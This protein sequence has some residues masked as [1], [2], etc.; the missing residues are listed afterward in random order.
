MWYNLDE[1]NQPVE[2]TI[3]E[4]IAW[5][6]KNPERKAVKQISVGDTYISTVFMGLDHGW[7]TRIPVLWETMI[8]GGKHD[9]YQKRYTSHEDAL[10]GHKI[11]IN[12]VK[13]EKYGIFYNIWNWISNGCAM[14]SKC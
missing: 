10:I 2:C 4:H 14:R 3:R 1:N 7:K 13:K 8:F 5:L 12:L 6:D 11:A 9:G